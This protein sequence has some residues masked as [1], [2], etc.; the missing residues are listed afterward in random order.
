MFKMIMSID[1]STSGFSKLEKNL[2]RLHFFKLNNQTPSTQQMA[3]IKLVSFY[4]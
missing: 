2:G 3:A 1:Q 4:Y